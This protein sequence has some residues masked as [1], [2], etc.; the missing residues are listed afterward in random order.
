M[1][2]PLPPL[3]LVMLLPSALVL[4]SQNRNAIEM[5]KANIKREK[6]NIVT[7][8]VNIDVHDRYSDEIHGFLEK[9]I[10]HIQKM[11]DALSDKV[12][13]GREDVQ[14]ATGLKPT[15]ASML[16]KELVKRKILEPVSGYGKGKYKFTGISVERQY[17]SWT[18][19]L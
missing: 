12:A 14:H 8:K 4:F 16:I 10:N 1:P 13:F 19:L 17:G 5:K 6:A 7:E 11:Y 3:L 2:P 18:E 15:R 9:T